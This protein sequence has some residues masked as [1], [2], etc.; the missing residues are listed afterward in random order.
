MTN[1]FWL[2]LARL[3][4]QI[5]PPIKGKS[6]IIYFL[7]KHVTPTHHAY[8]VIIQGSAFVLDLRNSTQRYTYYADDFEPDVRKTISSLVQP[9]DVIVDVGANFGFHTLIAA[10]AVGTSGR[11]YAFEPL[12]QAFKQLND[13]L[14]LNAIRHVITENVALGDHEAVENIYTF[15]DEPD[16]HASMHSSVGVVNEA[17]KCQVTTLDKYAAENLG[18]HRISLIKLDV[19][20][21][22]LSVL[23]GAKNILDNMRPNIIVEF[24]PKT[25]QAAGASQEELMGYLI[26]HRYTLKLLD[27]NSGKQT[28]LYNV[29]QLSH[30]H[31][32]NVYA[33]PME[34]ES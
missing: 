34:M 29:N 17:F 18:E 21:Y 10:N 8:Q 23:K 25:L 3:A 31:S 27:V 33:I 11:V 9:N 5:L 24:N 14:A 4:G 26:E 19:E 7:D 6:R 16:T 15:S 12:P 28:P 22:E 13:N 32:T 1:F 20:G 30:K 2:A